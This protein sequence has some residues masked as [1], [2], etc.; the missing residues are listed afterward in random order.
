MMKSYG[1]LTRLG[2]LRRMHQLARKALGNYGLGVQ[3]IKFLADDT[4]ISFKVRSTGGKDYVLRIYSDEETTLVEN[5]AEVF[6]LQ[7]LKRDTDLKFAEPVPRTDGKAI[8]I[9]KIPGVPGEK[10]CI[11]FTWVPGQ[12]LEKNLSPKNY[13]K[14]GV[15]MAKLHDHAESLRPLPAWIQPKKWDRAFYYPEEPVVY[16]DSAYRYLFSD[17]QIADIDQVIRIAD[18]EFSRLYADKERQILIHGDLHYWNVNLFR[19]ELYI[20]D[21]EDVMLGYPIQDAAICLYYGRH[22]EDYPEL[23]QAFMQGYTSLRAWPVERPWQ[24]E[25]L[26]AARS[27]NFVNYVARVEEAPQEYIQARCEEL[28]EFLDQIG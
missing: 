3:W 5:Q 27:V 8:T 14:L 6:W 2:K 1:E 28:H 15:T 13:Y 7:A 12:E 4:N 10:R 16:K 23:R 9:G 18:E 17:Q 20:L 21:F 25:I 11:L 22:R 26:Q 19:E 24:I